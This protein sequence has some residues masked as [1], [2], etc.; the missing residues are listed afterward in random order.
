MQ[1]SG[2]RGLPSHALGGFILNMNG[3]SGAQQGSVKEGQLLGQ[4]IWPQGEEGWQPKV[5]KLQEPPQRPQGQEV[6]GEAERDWHPLN[7]WN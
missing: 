7:W 6:Q 2:S 4:E 3:N 5:R 1:V